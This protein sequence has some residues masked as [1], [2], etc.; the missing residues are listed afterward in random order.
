MELSVVIAT[1]AILLMIAAPIFDSVMS[2]GARQTLSV[3]IS[4][5]ALRAEQAKSVTGQYP[6]ETNAAEWKKLRTGLRSDTVLVLRSTASGFCLEATSPSEPGFWM[7][8]ASS[9]ADPTK[10]RTVRDGR[11][12]V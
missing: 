11:C 10:T 4:G 9:G 7:S 1:L 6:Q 3:E 12:A 5:A 2:T 8:I